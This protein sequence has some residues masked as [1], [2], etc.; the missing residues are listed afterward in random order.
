MTDIFDGEVDV[1]PNRTRV[2]PIVAGLVA[3][4][5]VFGGIAAAVVTGGLGVGQVLLPAFLPY[6]ATQPIQTVELEVGIDL[7]EGSYAE[8]PHDESLTVVAQVV[9]PA[10]APDPLAG[11]DYTEVSDV[12]RYLLRIW[13]GFLDDPRYYV[14]SDGHAALTGTFDG[15]RII[16]FTAPATTEPAE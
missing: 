4:G 3:L 9:V 14:T 12:P 2:W 10:G 5:L 16:S 7:P 15:H 8:L 13:D 1:A 6:A 11:T